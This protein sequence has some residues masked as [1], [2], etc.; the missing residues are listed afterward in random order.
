MSLARKVWKISLPILILAL[1]AV[2]A[3][4]L[5]ANRKPPEKEAVETTGALVHVTVAEVADR[6][7]VV[8]GTGTVRPR[9][10]INVVPQVSGRV[11][12][13]SPRLVAGGFFKKGEVLFEIEDSDYRLALTRAE[14]AR[15]KAEY[16]LA[17]V[18][19][20]ARVAEAEWKK[21]NGGSTEAP[22]PL[23]LY[24]P[25]LKNARAALEAAE[26]A[27][28]QAELDLE[29]TRVRAPFNC[30]VSSEDVDP[31]QYV[32]PGSPVAVLSGT[33]V[34]EIVVPLPLAELR[35][36]DVPRETGAP[37]EKGPAATV[38]LEVGEGAYKWHGTV[39]RAHG[40]LDSRDRMMGVV[41]EVEDPYGLEG[42]SAPA[43]LASG[44][45]VTVDIEGRTVGDVV[46][47]P[48][49]ALRDGSTVWVADTGATLDIRKVTLVRREKNEVL[50]SGLASGDRV[51]LTTIA[52]AA[53]GLALRPVKDKG[54]GAP[55]S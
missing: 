41:V 8:S 48:R 30:R 38:S 49:G 21:L 55:G 26:A 12:R 29:R 54:E 46:A 27:V 20:Q 37:G 53:E 45:F 36:I 32:A 31:G 23:V 43:P 33:D 16:D 47:I 5:V 51:I 14:A 9:K 19:S 6:R 4:S 52:G 18:E 42:G 17:R 24:G 25:Q 50:V 44:A 2:V 3:G 10:L 28:E 40:E 35:W 11:E 15:V 13:V 39:T 34:A 1:G 7:V 22:N